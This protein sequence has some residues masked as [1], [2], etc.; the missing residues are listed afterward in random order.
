MND[1]R[2]NKDVSGDDDNGKLSKTNRQSMNQFFKGLGAWALLLVIGNAFDFAYKP[3]SYHHHQVDSSAV[4][5]LMM[6]SMG[7]SVFLLYFTGQIRWLIL[8]GAIGLVMLW[9]FNAT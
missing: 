2:D 9:I 6:H 5:A 8:N 4:S 3:I 1:N 7:F